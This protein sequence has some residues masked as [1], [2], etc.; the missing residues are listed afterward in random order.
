MIFVAAFQS[1][2]MLLIK[3]AMDEIFTNKQEEFI[4]PIVV[5]IV[6]ASIFKFYF[7]YRQRHL[8]SWIGQSVVR[9]I[10]NEMY[11]NLMNLSLPYFIKS[12]TGKL[13]SRLTYDVGLLQRSIVMIPR[14]TLRDGV[15]IIFYLGILFYL[16]WQWTF[17]AIISFPVISIVI[18]T[19][20]KK[21][22]RRSKAVQML[23]ADIYS[24]LQE[25]ITGIKLIKAT[26]KEQ[27]E[28]RFMEEQNQ[29]YFYK[30]MRMIKADI[31][32]SPLVELL[33]VIGIG[34]VI[35]WG[36]MEVIKGTATQG[37]FIAFIAVVMSLYKPAKALTNVNTDI[38]TA[39]SATERIFEIIDEKPTV[40]ESSDAKEMP[41]FSTE[42]K[43][44]NVSF[45]YNQNEPVLKNITL[46]IKKGK[47][48][49]LVGPSGGGK[50]TF[51]NLL[52][53]FFDPT[54]GKIT[55]DGGD[56]KDFTLK[57][58]RQQIGMVTQET[59]LFNDTVANNISYGVSGVNLENI[60]AAA[61]K[62]NAH[63]FITKFSNQYDTVI[64]EKGVMLSG[65]EKQRLAL[66]RMILRNP[67]ILILDEATSALDSESE[68]LVQEALARVMKEKTTIVIAHRLSTIKSADKIIVIDN[69]K[70]VAAGRHQELLKKSP[71]YKQLY[72]LQ[73]LE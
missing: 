52:V 65:G 2:L 66:A 41:G 4:L 54:S 16:N 36:G 33:A 18:I 71:L 60:T 35:I 8:L 10:R 23:T 25:K 7:T 19:I 64:G 14:N 61:E 51:V 27:D 20:G 49:A 30:L 28:I 38:Q 39:I 13:I 6:F 50:T 55:I 22:R 3:P 42:M 24:I 1:F 46:Q 29:N 44:E 31:L 45:E 69:G 15:Q 70:I 11:R 56:I 21:I 53:R 72:E 57:S 59:I 9:D 17:A 32:Q 37:T 5:G 47:T 58:L 12:S 73:Y 48:V 34:I 26:T 40:I 63:D 67:Q 68:M 43:F 62:A